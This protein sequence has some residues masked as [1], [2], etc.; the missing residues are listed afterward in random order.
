MSSSD[1]GTR[2]PNPRII[3]WPQRTPAELLSPSLRYDVVGLAEACHKASQ[4]TPFANSFTLV[5][6]DQSG[7]SGKLE[8]PMKLT[9]DTLAEMLKLSKDVKSVQVVAL[10]YDETYEDKVSAEDQAS[11]IKW[12]AEELETS[13]IFFDAALFRKDPP[14]TI[15]YPRVEAGVQY[16]GRKTMNGFYVALSS[17]EPTAVWFS[18]SLET[19]H[20]TYVVNITDQRTMYG[21]RAFASAS[22]PQPLFSVDLQLLDDEFLFTAVF[23]QEVDNAKMMAESMGTSGF[24][25]DEYLH[26]VGYYDKMFDLETAFN[27]KRHI[28]DMLKKLAHSRVTLVAEHPEISSA[29]EAAAWKAVPS[30]IMNI[31][32][33]LDNDVQTRESRI[34]TRL[35]M[36][37]GLLNA[38]LAMSSSQIAMDTK[39][40]SSSMSTIAAMTLVFL[41]GS[42]MAAVYGTD[43]VRKEDMVWWKFALC[44][45]L[46]TA[47][48]L[49]IYFYYNGGRVK[50][51]LLLRRWW[52]R[53]EDH[54]MVD[55]AS[56]VASNVSADESGSNK[57]NTFVRKRVPPGP[58]IS[59]RYTE[60]VAGGSR[61]A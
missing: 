59:P 44:T 50:I 10:A 21:L 4:I 30:E 22:I 31:L 25:V 45:I 36:I 26:I 28:T 17:G 7:M 35:T 40:D 60:A 29:K 42:F 23:E 1:K 27:R 52:N 41:P 19:G 58:R 55:S 5:S 61:S 38:R 16:T 56:I 15:L 8:G 34:A 43:V 53:P 51:M 9:P 57:A 2:V 14:S 54:D 6:R 12:L 3:Q 11:A 18:H 32:Y 39:K 24:G 47:L 33:I 46:L 49:V 20:S 48:V 13:S 37:S